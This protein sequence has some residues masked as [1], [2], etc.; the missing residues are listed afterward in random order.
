VLECPA[1][2]IIVGCSYL[3]IVTNQTVHSMLR[4]FMP[5][6]SLVHRPYRSSKSPTSMKQIPRSSKSKLFLIIAALSTAVLLPI[7]ILPH[8]NQPYLVYRS[9]IHVISIIISIFLVVVSI[10]TY[11]RTG[12]IKILYTSVAFLSLLVVEL[13]FLLQIIPGSSELMLPTPIRMLPYTFLLVMLALFGLGVLRV[14]R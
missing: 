4:I 3:L 8:I 13:I 5:I 6:Y 11:R 7:A 10:L 1:K 14:E 2:I 9:S 12:S